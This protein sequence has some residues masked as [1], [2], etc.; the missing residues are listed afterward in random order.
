M[1]EFILLGFLMDHNM[2]GYDIKQMMSMSTSNFVDSSFGSI[3]PALKKLEQKDWISSQEIIEG[4]KIKKV[5]SITNQGREE[6]LKWL[7]LPI[8]ASKTGVTSA[9]SKIFFFDHLPY[10]TA[11]KLLT[12]Y[13]AD[14]ISFKNNL[15]AI[16]DPVEQKAAAFELCTLYFGLDFYDFGIQWFQNYLEKLTK[17]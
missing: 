10:E 6:F 5:Y 9:L 7:N 11:V 4:G 17:K 14:L 1:T 8:E 12:A 2:T 3:Y 16:K 13:I 15:L